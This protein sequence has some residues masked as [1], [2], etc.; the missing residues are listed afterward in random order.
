MV[1]DQLAAAVEQVGQAD[2]DLLARVVDSGEGVRLL[3]LD[4]GQGATL[5][6]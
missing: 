1:D 6:C 4:Y 3:Y 2:L 5:S